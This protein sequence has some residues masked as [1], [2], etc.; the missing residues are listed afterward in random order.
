M[1]CKIL[2]T[3][4]E[5]FEINTMNKTH[6]Q[7]ETKKTK[8]DIYNSLP[9]CTREQNDAYFDKAQGFLESTPWYSNCNSVV[10]CA[11][12]DYLAFSDGY[13]LIRSS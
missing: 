4:E 11:I 5:S 6:G 7:I 12:A 13:K 8:L 2:S 9:E 3:T 1:P 10:K